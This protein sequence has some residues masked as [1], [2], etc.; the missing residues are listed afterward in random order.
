MLIR[1]GLSFDLLDTAAA[2]SALPRLPDDL[3]GRLRRPAPRRPGGPRALCALR[4]Q[5]DL[6]AG[7]AHH[8]TSTSTRARR[9]P[10]RCS[11]RSARP[12]T[13]RTGRGSTRWGAPARLARR[14]DL[15]A[16]ALS[17][18]PTH[19]RILGGAGAHGEARGCPG[20]G[21][22]RVARTRL[23]RAGAAATPLRRAV[24]GSARH[25]RLDTAPRGTEA[26]GAPPPP[27]AALHRMMRR[28]H[29]RASVPDVTIF[30]HRS[31]LPVPPEIGKRSQDHEQAEQYEQDQH[32]NEHPAQRLHR[33]SFVR[34]HLDRRGRAYIS[35]VFR[36]LP[37]LTPQAVTAA[38]RPSREVAVLALSGR[39]ARAPWSSTS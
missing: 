31:D 25:R 3:A 24:G 35:S 7:A 10:T 17:R 20:V 36:V 30:L 4:R 1:S 18:P 29:A 19:W 2:Q 34:G 28:V 6:L 33:A 13:P 9:W 23:G 22:R 14:A 26:T 21:G 12:F 5:A 38:A 27:G 11:P 15:R 32:S 37:D 8:S 16:L 39:A